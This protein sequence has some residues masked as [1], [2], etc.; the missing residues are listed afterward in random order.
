MIKKVSIGFR[1]SLLGFNCQDVIDYIEKT[2]NTFVKKEKDL[3][4]QVNSLSEELNLSKESNKKLTQEKE[5]IEKKLSD[6]NEKYDEIEKLS[7]NIGKLYLVAQANAQAIMENSRKNAEI[8]KE[9]IDKNLFTIDEAHSSLQ[10]LRRNITR[11]SE[12]F[13]AEVDSLI[14]SLAD[15]KSQIVSNTENQNEASSNFD[16]VYNSIVK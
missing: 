13:V 14:S 12:K 8:A 9:E 3:S 1:K 4:N 15:T 6:F 2:H 11:T 5:I 16:E 7:E 10:E